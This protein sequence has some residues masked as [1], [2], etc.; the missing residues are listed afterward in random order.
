[1]TTPTIDEDLAAL[2]AA[3]ANFKQMNEIQR[4]L[5][6]A[7]IVLGADGDEYGFEQLQR[8][9]IAEISGLI[10]ALRE[11]QAD[12]ISAL[13]LVADLR[14]AMGDNG[15]RMQDELIEWARGLACAREDAERLR[16]VGAQLGNVA[17]NLAQKPGH[18]LTSDDVSMLDKLRRQW[19]DAAR[20]AT[21]GAA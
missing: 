4:R 20:A 3:P 19:D 18:A 16:S 1:M 10:A 13:R 15:K 2:S 6:N 5:H 9:A 17:Y 7:A 21:K 11:A 14:F 8:D 12:Q